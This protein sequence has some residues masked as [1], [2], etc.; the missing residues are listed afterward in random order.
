VCQGSSCTSTTTMSNRPI[1]NLFN[2]YDLLHDPYEE[3][4]LDS[5]EVINYCEA[6]FRVALQ[7]M[8]CSTDMDQSWMTRILL[9]EL[10]RFNSIR[11][12]FY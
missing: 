9:S 11:T 1:V 5:Q 3:D 4:R 6:R 7:G 2:P 8:S 12:P 10:V